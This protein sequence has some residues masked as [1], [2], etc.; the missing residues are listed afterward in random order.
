MSTD[1]MEKAKCQGRTDINWFP[2]KGQNVP[3]VIK[4]CQDCPVR[5][6]CFDYAVTN[7]YDD[8][9]WG[10]VSANRR[11]QYRRSLSRK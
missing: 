10:G 11:A 7:G 1:W 8:G 2:I 4:F 6:A 3:D 9:V 5:Q